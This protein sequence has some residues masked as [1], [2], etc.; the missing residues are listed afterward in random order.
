MAPMA[1]AAAPSSF[2]VSYAREDQPFVKRL[3]AALLERDREVWVDWAAVPALADWRPE[4]TAA[5]EAAD[6]FV[7]VISDDSAA[8]E[9]CLMEVEVAAAAR[10]RF[11]PLVRED[12]EA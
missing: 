5:I 6:V 10:K 12:V 3:Y 7:F 8:S 11:A 4:V 1:T 2:F 9:V